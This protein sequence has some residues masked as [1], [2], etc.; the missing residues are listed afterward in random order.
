MLSHVRSIEDSLPA[1]SELIA[2]GLLPNLSINLQ[3][4]TTSWIVHSRALAHSSEP[5]MWQQYHSF[6]CAFFPLASQAGPFLLSLINWNPV[7]ICAISPSL[8]ARPRTFDQPPAFRQGSGSFSW[9]QL[10]AIF[11]EHVLTLVAR[12]RLTSPAPLCGKLLIDGPCSCWLGIWALRASHTGFIAASLFAPAQIWVSRA[13]IKYFRRCL[14]LPG[15]L[16]T[17]A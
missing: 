17:R 9:R 3:S 4:S 8:S 12:A 10:F 6:V 1:L 14:R 15:S 2:S 5:K 7:A 13:P 16:Q 11:N